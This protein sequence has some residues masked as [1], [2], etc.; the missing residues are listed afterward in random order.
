VPKSTDEP[1]C[2]TAAN[3]GQGSCDVTKAEQHISVLSKIT[4][5]RSDNNKHHTINPQTAKD[6]HLA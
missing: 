2:I 6:Q 1:G 4:T 5:Y 3:P